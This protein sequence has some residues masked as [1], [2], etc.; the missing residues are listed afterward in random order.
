[1][2]MSGLRIMRFDF[3]GDSLGEVISREEIFARIF[4][5][6]EYIYNHYSKQD[7]KIYG[8]YFDCVS[9]PIRNDFGYIYVDFYRFD[10]WTSIVYEF[11]K[12]FFEN[13]P[14]D[15]EYIRVFCDVLVKKR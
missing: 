10:S 8:L 1:M 12:A 5:D 4:N 6:L 14:E 9:K 7:V 2:I 11:T 15:K 3:A 13:I